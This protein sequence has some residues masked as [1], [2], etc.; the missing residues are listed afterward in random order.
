MPRSICRTA[1]MA[2]ISIVLL[3]SAT[4]TRAEDSAASTDVRAQERQIIRGDCEYLAYRYM[5]FLESEQGKAAGLFTEDGDAFGH[6][7]RED[8]REFFTSIEEGDSN[9]NVL[10][11]SN[12]VIEVLDENRATA[13]GYVTHYASAPLDPTKKG[14]MGRPVGGELSTP[15][16]VT[17]WDWEFRRVDG[18]WLISKLSYPESVLLRKDVLDTL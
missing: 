1:L 15:K 6:V 13:S 9:V 18:E 12:L 8:I 3:P 14:P 4:A 10:Q 2:V 7:G 5:R 17:R 11:S 16:S